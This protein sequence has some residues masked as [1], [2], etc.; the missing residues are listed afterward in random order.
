MLPCCLG[1]LW[2]PQSEG[3]LQD[4]FA[5]TDWDVF[6]A[7]ATWE[8]F[9][10]SI[11]DYAEYVT[12]Y[13]STCVDNIIPT[14]QVR[15]FPNQKPWIN[16]QVRHM[17]RARSF[18]FTSGN[19]TEYK[20]AKYGL[21]KDI[22]VAKRQ[23]REKLD[24]FYSNADAGRMWQ[25]LQRITDYRP[26]TSTTISSLDSLPD[27]LNTFYACFETSS[28]NT[29]WRHTHIG[30]TQSPFSPPTVCSCGTQS[31]EEDQPPKGS[32]ARQHPWA[33]PQSLCYRGG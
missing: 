20:A 6:K 21:R 33:G 4:C 7:A 24:S 13:I 1:K 11:Q 19:E 16:S 31:T 25:G 8:D 30:T 3:I 10:V 26:T 28:D 2:I 12:A 5:L 27:D 14:I 22:T 17:L 9:S 32:G 23:Y 15:K 29:E 18:A